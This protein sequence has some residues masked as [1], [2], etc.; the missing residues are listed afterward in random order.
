MEKNFLTIP[1]EIYLLSIDEHGAQLPMF[2]N[3][4]F[5]TL[6]SASILMELAI[7]HKIDSDQKYIIPDK[8]GMTGNSILDWAIDEI[9][10]FGNNRRI[11]EWISHFSVHGQFFRDEII[12]SLVRKEVLSIENEKVLWFFNRRKYPMVNNVE[13]IEVKSRIKT[14]IHG[15][16]LPNERDIV[17]V[18][19]LANSNLLE[20]IFTVDEIKTYQLRIEQI[21]QMDFIGQAIGGILGTFKA[22]VFEK[23][24]KN[25]S[26][27]DMLEAHIEDLKKKFRITNESNL[28]EWIRKGTLQYEKTLLFVKEKGTAQVSY[29]PKTKE[30]ALLNLSYYH[31]P[32]G[33]S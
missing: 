17:I 3:E 26:P 7:L 15:N 9:D 21:A 6:L 28:P 18:S 5:D 30:Y 32:F 27:E 33:V 31:S 1:E 25:D 20:A 22:S 19:I 12:T 10:E 4:E 16:D 11:D 24:F 13:V 23:L 2:T 29:N 8:T 14:L